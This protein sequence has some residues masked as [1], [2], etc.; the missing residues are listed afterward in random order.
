MKLTDFLTTDSID[1]NLKAESKDEVLQRLVSLL[2]ISDKTWET[3]VKM[4]KKRERLGSTG[5]GKGVA[6]PHGRSLLINRLM[7]AFA[8]SDEGIDF[9]SVDGE[10]SQLFFLIMAPP[11][12]VSNLYL[13]TLGKIAQISREK[14]NRE[15]L[16]AAETPEKLI[17]V[18]DRLERGTHT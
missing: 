5:I 9:D 14:E 12:E 15:L 18:L 3:L 10:P 7:L 11:L 6:I 16:A 2:P 4:L 1:L 17:T 13:P 8:R